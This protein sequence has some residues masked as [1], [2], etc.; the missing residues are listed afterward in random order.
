MNFDVEFVFVHSYSSNSPNWCDVMLGDGAASG[1]V[2][3]ALDL[4]RELGI[5]VVANDSRDRRNHALYND[6]GIRNIGTALNTEDEVQSA[7][8]LSSHGR[9]LFVTSPD[10]LPRV[11]RDTLVAGGVNCL[12]CASGVPFSEEGVRG[13]RVLEPEHHKGEFAQGHSEPAPR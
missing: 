12:F 10:H 7:L 6:K 13:V 5:P 3:R 11:V 8:S 9:V 1:R 2:G 4:G